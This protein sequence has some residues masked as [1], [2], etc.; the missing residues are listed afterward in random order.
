[1][2]F[3]FSRIVA[4]VRK[5]ATL[6]GFCLLVVQAA[7]YSFANE[8]SWIGRWAGTYSCGNIRNNHFSLDITA[9]S[10]NRVEGLFSFN[11]PAA[12]GETGAYKVVGRSGSDG[13]VTFVPQE[14]VERPEGF[15]PLGLVAA[16]HAN[17]QMLEGNIPDCGFG[18]D[19]SASRQGDKAAGEVEPPDLSLVS[20]TPIS[21]GLIQGQWLGGITCKMNRREPQTYGVEAHMVQDGAG[22]AALFRIRIFKVRGSNSG[23][24]FDQVVVVSGLAEDQR[25]TLGNDILLEGKNPARFKGLEVALGAGGN[26]LT[27]T[28]TMN[29]CQDIELKRSGSLEPLTVAGPLHDLWS[30][31][32]GHTDITVFTAVGAIPNFIELRASFPIDQPVAARDRLK[33][34]LIPL[35]AQNGKMLLV[36]VGVREA[37]GV[38]DR[39]KRQATRHT[40]TS[41]RAL[42]VPEQ[43]ND[44][45]VLWNV[46]R[47]QDIARVMGAGAAVRTGQNDVALERTGKELA[48]E[49]IRGATT[50]ITLGGS[51]A[52]KLAAAPSLEA[53]CATL[54]TWLE[55]Y[56]GDTDFNR[57]SPAAGTRIILDALS[58]E[59]FVP[60]FGVPFS[61]LA[62]SERK[63]I[64][65]L[66]RTH[67]G[68]AMEMRQ[69]TNLVVQQPFQS[70]QN[71]IRT[72]VLMTNRIEAREWFALERA[73]V[74]QLPDKA[75]SLDELE[76]LGQMAVSRFKEVS[77]AEEEEFRS[78]LK[79]RSVAIETQ[80]LRDKLEALLKSSETPDTL[81][82]M[83]KL[84]DEL[85]K[86]PAPDSVKLELLKLAK[87]KAVAIARPIYLAAGS[88]AETLPASL[89][90]LAGIRRILLELA[91]T[92][93]AMRAHFGGDLGELLRPVYARERTLLQDPLVQAAFRA[94]L[95]SVESKGD[96]YE[97][98]R[99]AA[100]LYV[101]PQVFDGAAA[102]PAFQTAVL[103]ATVAAEMRAVEFRDNSK[104]ITPGEPTAEDIFR[105]IQGRLL[106]GNEK[107][108]STEQ[109]CLSGG[110]K[111]DPVLALECL[112]ILSLTGGQG[113]MRVRVTKFEKLG[114]SP[115][116]AS[117][118]YKCL[119]SIAHTSNSPLLTGRLGQLFSTAEV[120]DGLFIHGAD[121]T[122]TMVYGDL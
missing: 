41:T 31:K 12:P 95:M 24:T 47:D 76:R 61:L 56:L 27:G 93:D 35:Y 8:P 7:P 96:P 82:Q 117:N 62:P 3:N 19:F 25:L 10:A 90:G 6:L 48:G 119:F 105:L 18:S 15:Q 36:P 32:L 74:K 33:M 84:M 91:P 108:R 13:R 85:A 75:A 9:Q 104:T 67:C 80:V 110:F 89:E 66:M 69:F 4:L 73:K 98:V 37:T 63:T 40:L 121:G 45:L 81:F 92:R 23:D 68:R 86:V 14:W 22:V 30:G 70:E 103:D 60:V 88:R 78:L 2:P 43:A 111:D 52:G 39:T 100:R 79:E 20:P 106:T 28:V 44:T 122:W 64:G 49:L 1:V 26:S 116:P 107:I 101:N 21:G 57:L 72:S 97:D 113:G 50:P 115:E 58:D 46:S 42:V 83:A 59:V 114:C 55:P 112:Q 94:E 53:Q 120:Q 109:V 5:S 17:G 99:N 51:F 29:G 77:A 102:V 65:Q 54:Q 71:F 11:V 87:T 16:L 38:F 34:V 118:Q